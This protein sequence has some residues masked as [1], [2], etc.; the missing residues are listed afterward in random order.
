MKDLWCVRLAELVQTGVVN[1]AHSLNRL[2]HV[3]KDIGYTLPAFLIYTAN[4]IC[5]NWHK[6]C[7]SKPDH[8]FNVIFLFKIGW[9]TQSCSLPLPSTHITHTL[10]ELLAWQKLGDP[11]LW[12][13]T[14]HIDW[15][16]M[17]W[18][19]GGLQIWTMEY[20]KLCIGW[21]YEILACVKTSTKSMWIPYALLLL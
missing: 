2:H 14:S 9:S 20:S 7:T 17:Y 13:S 16:W 12:F 8:G 4:L 1:Y 15:E 11:Q 5:N 18:C 21:E 10:I 6:A 19:E 3:G